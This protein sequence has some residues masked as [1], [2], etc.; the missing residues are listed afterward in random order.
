MDVIYFSVNNWDETGSPDSASFNEWLL[1][2]NIDKY[3]GSKEWIAE[4]ELI[5]VEM[6]VD[7]SVSFIVSAKREWVEKHCPEIIGSEFDCTQRYIDGNLETE[8]LDGNQYYL[9][10]IW[11]APIIEYVPDNIGKRYIFYWGDENKLK[12]L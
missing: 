10:P 4:N 5:V 1:D 7:M 11:S 3:F 2:S 12:E 8:M 6:G 9:D